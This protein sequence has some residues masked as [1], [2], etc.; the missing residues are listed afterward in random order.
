VSSSIGW[1]WKDLLLGKRETRCPL[2]SA[3]RLAVS[4]AVPDVW[5]ASAVGERGWTAPEDS[6]EED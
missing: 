5:D 4:A 2:P 6:V 1:V 3:H